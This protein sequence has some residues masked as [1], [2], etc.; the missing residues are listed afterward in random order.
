MKFL[1]YEDVPLYIAPHGQ[2]GE[3]IFAE[4]ASLSVTQ[5]NKPIRSIEDNNLSICEFGLGTSMNYTSPVFTANS[6][7]NVTLGPSGGPPQPLPASI[8][9]IPQDT[10]ITFPNG[11]HLYFSSDIFPDGHDYVVSLYSK[12]GGWRLDAN[13]AQ[14]GYFESIYDYVSTGPAQ[15]KLDVNF[16]INT[17]N[18]QSFFNITGLVNPSQYPPINETKLTGFLGDFAFS[19]AHLQSLSFSLSPNSI[20]QASATFGIYGEI[21][22]IN[23]ITDSYFNSSLYAQQSIPHGQNSNIIGASPLGIEHP[24]S[25]NYSIE[26]DTAPRYSAP[27]GSSNGSEGIFPDRVSKKSTKIS[28]GIDGES[29]DPEIVSDG[30]IAKRANLKVILKDLSYDN[31]EDNS[32]GFMHTFEC[33]G[34]INAQAL[35]V[36]SQD[37]LNGSISVSQLL[38]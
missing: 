37:Y 15:G 8:Y 28:M 1:P 16:Y 27:T 34:V 3:Y 20:S 31:F 29:I 2:N 12:S 21:E 38:R 6:T 17:G 19:C 18:L 5:P 32:N 30:G 26:V 10:K 36:N 7:H 24:V 4:T 11:K 33:S 14:S 25:F 35:S 23:G 13:E 22:K 9:K